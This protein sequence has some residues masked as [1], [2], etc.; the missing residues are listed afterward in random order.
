MG[1]QACTVS[2]S[3]SFTVTVY[4]SREKVSKKM[5]ILNIRESMPEE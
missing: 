5:A 2:T 4:V 3:D 1:G